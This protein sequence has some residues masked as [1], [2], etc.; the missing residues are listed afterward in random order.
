MNKNFFENE[1]TGKYF[2]KSLAENQTLVEFHLAWNHLRAK[3]CG[4]LLK[5]LATNACLTLLDLS[6]NGAHLLA[7]K[8][9]FE[10]LRKNT[11]LEK[12]YLDN[13]QL[14]K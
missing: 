9:I 11:T 6:W 4:L 14:N 7:A 2:G 5:P 10:L 12:L 1:S 13:N 3:A 8:A